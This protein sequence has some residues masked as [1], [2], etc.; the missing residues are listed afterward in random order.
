MK[1]EMKPLFKE[2][3]QKLLPETGDFEEFSRIIHIPPKNFIRCNTLKISVDELVKKLSKKWEIS[4]PHYYKS[5]A[6]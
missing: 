6:D 2:R 1:Y 5:P 3:M 4:Q